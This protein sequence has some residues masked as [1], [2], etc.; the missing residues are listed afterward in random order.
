MK[1]SYDRKKERMEGIE[2]MRMDE[3]RYSE[4]RASNLRPTFN[5]LYKDKLYFPPELIPDGVKYMWVRISTYGKPDSGNSIKMSKAGWRAVPADRHPEYCVKDILGNSISNNNHIEIEGLVLCE[6]SIEE[7][8]REERE[9]S[10]YTYK[11]TSQAPG[12]DVITDPSMPINNESR[13]GYSSN[14]RY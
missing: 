12:L 9:I 4:G 8:L 13:F 6:R 5:M 3:S 1:E 14:M 2:K 7:C 10:E 11:V